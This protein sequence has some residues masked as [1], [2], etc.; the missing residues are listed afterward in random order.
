MVTKDLLSVPNKWNKKHR[1]FNQRMIP[2]RLAELARQGVYFDSGIVEHPVIGKETPIGKEFR[3]MMKDL[4]I[5]TYSPN[6]F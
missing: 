6:R 3:E 5:Q 4:G 2:A 1:P